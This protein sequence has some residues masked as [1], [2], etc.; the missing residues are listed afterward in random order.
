MRHSTGTRIAAAMKGRGPDALT[1]LTDTGEERRLG[2][3]RLL[4]CGGWQPDLTLW[5]VAGGQSRWDRQTGRLQPV[6]ELDGIVLA[7]SAAGWF[8]RSAAIQSGA[9]A[10]DRLL[11]RSRKPVTDTLIDALYETPAAPAVSAAADDDAAPAYLDT[12]T[13]L[14]LRPREHRRSWL[15][16]LRPPRH[17]GLTALSEAPQPL[18]VTTVASGVDLGLIPPEAAGA[19]AQERVALMPL[20][21]NESVATEAEEEKDSDP[22]AI[23]DYLRGRF[24]PGE[25]LAILVPDQPRRVEPGMLIFRSSDGNDP[26]RAIGVV[27]RDAKVGALA[28]VAEQALSTGLTVSLR[29]ADRAVPARLEPLSA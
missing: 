29:D 21:L 27:I 4:V 3:E 11:G 22:L 14:I 9:D 1:I 10:V 12:G 6:G 28:L 24:G 20:A 19:V 16:W 23:P 13:A 15:D 17:V 7:G 8:T 26:R 25:N 2:T 18:T 5:H